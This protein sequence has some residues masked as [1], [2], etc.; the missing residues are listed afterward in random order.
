MQLH[1]CKCQ[2]WYFYLFW[3]LYVEKKQDVCYYI[4]KGVIF[5]FVN[6]DLNI[7]VTKVVSALR[8]LNSP[9]DTTIFRYKRERWA[10]VLKLSGKTIYSIDG[11]HF[12]SDKYHPA[13]L[14]K[15]CSY[16]WQCTEPGE[17]IVIEFE[18]P[19]EYQK[20][21]SFEITNNSLL[22]KNFLKV[23]S[24]S[25]VQGANYKLECTCLLYEMIHFLLKSLNKEYITSDKK[26]ILRPAIEYIAQNY[27]VNN[28]TNDYLANLCSISTVYFRKTFEKI[29]GAPPIKYLNQLRIEKAKSILLSDYDSIGQVAK[30]I[31]YNSIYHFS[32]MFKLYTGQSPSEYTKASRK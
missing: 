1:I 13:L 3:Y 29:Y 15:G 24:L 22:T 27:Y 6:Y 10:L 23:E 8:L 11:A 26:D 31:G 16:S 25:Y 18:A 2:L 32:K 30:S 14:P 17:C 20:I 5:T 21:F 19:E 12:V 28:I 4:N 7:T 9:V